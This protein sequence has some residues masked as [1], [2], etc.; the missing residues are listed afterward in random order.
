MSAHRADAIVVGGGAIG[1]AVAWQLAREGVAVRLFERGALGGEASG[2]AAGMLAPIT[3]S[4]GSGPLLGPGLASLELHAT[5]AAQLLEESGVDVELARSGILRVAEDDARAAQLAERAGPHGVAWLG[6]R[7]LAA[8]C[9][10]AAPSLRGALFSPSEG[11]LRSASFVR[12]LALA[13][14]RRGARIET[15]VAVRGLL[16][17]G[18]RVTGVL[19]S[20][21]AAT[22]GVI[23]LCTGAFARDCEAWLGEGAQLP[24]EP[25]RGQMVA[26]EG[27]AGAGGPIVWGDAAYLIPRRDGSLAIGATVERVGFDRSVTADGVRTLLDA[28]FTLMPALRSARFLE[29]WAGLRPASPD[30]LP[31]VGPWPGAGGLV[32]AAG[33]T[34]NG[35][36]L[37]P[38]TAQLVADG[39][40]G[41]G[42]R[43]PAFAPGR[44]R[45]QRSP[46]GG[47]WS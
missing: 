23:V 28:A 36:L 11:N 26:V 7:E 2:A 8:L 19:T 12:A 16:R 35:I 15:G 31:L 17:E 29:A 18:E 40:L 6:P 45:A 30:H 9:P 4:G 41:K 13:A 10:G 47:P 5:W 42:W 14:E 25:V 38:L 3:E 37:A 33:H 34:R 21:G 1:C 46:R 43:E 20:A 39:V 32:I 22:A 44:F 27:P 24:V